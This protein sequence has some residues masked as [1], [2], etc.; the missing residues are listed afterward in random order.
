MCSRIHGFIR[1][2]FIVYLTVCYDNQLAVFFLSKL[3]LT[4]ISIGEIF[5]DIPFLTGEAF[6]H[7]TEKYRMLVM[8]R[9]WSYLKGIVVTMHM[10]LSL[11]VRIV[12]SISVTFLLATEVFT[13]IL[14]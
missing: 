9:L 12:L 11:T 1:V 8:R 7:R 6:I 3:F 10:L 4:T 14:M 2:W 13:M 5:S